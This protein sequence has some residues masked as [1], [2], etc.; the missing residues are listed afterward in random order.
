MDSQPPGLRERKKAATRLALHEAALRLVLRDGLA[1]VTVEAIADAADVSRRTFSNY[2]SGKEE[3]LLYGDQTRMRAFLDT[4]RAR[5]ADETP[6]TALRETLVAL[7][8]TFGSRG[9]GVTGQLRLLRQQPD[10]I[11][12]QAAIYAEVEQELAAEFTARGAAPGLQA[13]ILAATSMAAIRVATTRWIEDNGTTPLPDLV[14]T[15]LL[16]IR[17]AFPTP[18]TV[19]PRADLGRI[20]AV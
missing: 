20:P 4:M 19:P 15:A 14:D 6:W 18:P 16:L 7:R 10:L 9:P 13:R 1:N 8:D 2:F 17:P 12:R 3:A 5:P 11:S